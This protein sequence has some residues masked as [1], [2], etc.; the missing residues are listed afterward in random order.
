M[1]LHSAAGPWA[2]FVGA[3]HARISNPFIKL[4][5]EAVLASS[6][7]FCPPP[8]WRC[9][10]SS[11]PLTHG[12]PSSEARDPSATVAPEIF[13]SAHTI[14]PEGIIGPSPVPNLSSP[15]TLRIP[16]SGR[17]RRPV[18]SLGW[19]GDLLTTSLHPI[20]FFCLKINK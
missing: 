13:S 18:V 10:G 17:G 6:A 7:F 2:C 1:G 11:S 12:G 3:V 9:A 16:G 8:T 15:L 19:V 5:L 4:L 20:L 14:P